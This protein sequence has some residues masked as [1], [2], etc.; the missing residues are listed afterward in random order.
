M[1]WGD[2]K[3]A[4]A[5]DDQV[6]RRVLHSGKP[7]GFEGIASLEGAMDIEP[8]TAANG[9]VSANAGGARME[10]QGGSGFDING[11][12][13]GDGGLIESG[14]EGRAGEG[15]AS[16]P[17]E[18]EG[19]TE[20]GHLKTGG[21]EG[22]VN[23]G[24]GVGKRITVGSATDGDTEVSAAREPDDVDEAGAGAGFD[25]A[26]HWGTNRMRSPGMAQSAGRGIWVSPMRRQPP[27]EA[28]G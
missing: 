17:E 3:V 21:G 28:A 14:G 27:G 9:A 11:L 16:R 24:V 18:A 4:I 6:L 19:R 10:T 7:G 8:Q 5:D 12:V 20:Q 13:I 26:D 23:Q 2:A 1:P 25:D 22:I 15:N